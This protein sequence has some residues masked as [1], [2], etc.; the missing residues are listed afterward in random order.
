MLQEA[1]LGQRR[2]SLEKKNKENRSKFLKSERNVWYKLAVK[3]Y[4]YYVL[5]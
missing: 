2:K 4:V 5:T 3:L 1:Y